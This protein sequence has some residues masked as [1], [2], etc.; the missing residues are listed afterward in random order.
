MKKNGQNKTIFYRTNRSVSFPP[1]ITKV[2]KT[3]TKV[4]YIFF[5]YWH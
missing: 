5:L 3:I 1:Y 4:I 2:M